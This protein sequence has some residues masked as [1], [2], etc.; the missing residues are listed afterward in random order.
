MGMVFCRGCGK[1]I[2]ETAPSCPHCG[3]P[4]SGQASAAT[5]PKNQTVAALLCAFLGGFGAHRFYLGKILSG[6]VYL[7]FCWTGI[8]ALIAFFELFGIVFA[9][10]QKWATAHNNGQ[11]TSP[12]NGFV[13][14]LA[15]F[16]PVLFIIGIVAAVLIPQYNAYKARKVTNTEATSQPQQTQQSS[17]MIDRDYDQ[18]AIRDLKNSYVA[19]QAY[20]SKEPKG[21]VTLQILYSYGLKPS[22]GV[23]VTVLNGGSDSLKL[24]SKYEKSNSVHVIDSMGNITKDTITKEMTWSPSFDCAKV[25]TGPE[26]LICSNR[27]LSEVDVQ[28]AQIYKAALKNSPDKNGLKRQQAAWLKNERDACS[29][30]ESMM[31]VYKERI[32]QLSR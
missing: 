20:F 29:N 8:P 5:S 19:A 30:A 14:A 13:K 2:H 27:E 9:S 16:F 7:L 11:L 23:S 24:T 4:Q 26:R 31:K 25:S 32:V 3:A 18:T 22:N 21:I 28:L 10:P 12:V 1:E 15:L 17:E 6:V